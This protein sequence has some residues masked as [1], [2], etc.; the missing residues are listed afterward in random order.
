M[1]AIWKEC[2]KRSCPAKYVWRRKAHGKFSCISLCSTTEKY[3]QSTST[4][5]IL[6]PRCEKA[7]PFRFLQTDSLPDF[8]IFNSKVSAI[9]P[10]SGNIYYRV[11][12]ARM[13]TGQ[14]HQ[15]KTPPVEPWT[16]RCHSLP[17][18]HLD[19]WSQRNGLISVRTV[20]GAVVRK[21]ESEREQI[22]GLAL[23]SRALSL[24]LLC[25][26]VWDAH[27]IYSLCCI[28]QAPK[29]KAYE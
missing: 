3:V 19:W 28:K 7:A 6:E 20:L 14:S 15:I 25:L 11:L 1:L 16:I 17:S 21:K 26:S 9:A 10:A 27:A 2:W 23:V 4:A 5:P 29:I 22:P 8:N 18:L 24:M 12:L 13:I